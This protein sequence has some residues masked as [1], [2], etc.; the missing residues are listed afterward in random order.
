MLILSFTSFANNSAEK[1]VL[2]SK[3]DLINYQELE[4]SFNQEEASSKSILAYTLSF[5]KPG[6]TKNHPI[7]Y[8]KYAL[9]KSDYLSIEQICELKTLTAEYLLNTFNLKSAQASINEITKE[10]PQEFKVYAQLKQGW[11]YVNK[12]EFQK[13]IDYWINNQVALTE[14]KYWDIA[15]KKMGEILVVNHLKKRKKIILKGKYLSEELLLAGVLEK[16]SKISP[17]E[18]EVKFLKDY[19]QFKNMVARNYDFFESSCDLDYL[20]QN[21]ID[22]EIIIKKINGCLSSKSPQYKKIAPLVEEL[23]DL[24]LPAWQIRAV[25]FS[26]TNQKQMACDA[27]LSCQILSE[28]EDYLKGVRENCNESDLVS[29]INQIGVNSD[30]TIDFMGKNILKL[31]EREPVL[32]RLNEV[33][34]KKLFAYTLND[35]EVSSY[36][37]SK[38]RLSDEDSFQFVLGHSQ[39]IEEKEKFVSTI[40]DQKTRIAAKYILGL[41]LDESLDFAVCDQTP[42][43]QNFLFMAKLTKNIFTP[44]DCFQEKLK[45]DQNL[46][47]HFIDYQLRNEM[48]YQLPSFQKLQPKRDFKSLRKDLYLNSSIKQMNFHKSF[49]KFDDYEFFNTISILKNM[50]NKVLKNQWLSQELRKRTVESFNQKLSRIKHLAARKIQDKKL[51]T[52]LEEMSL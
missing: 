41:P 1:L 24:T 43:L 47:A 22:E 18:L 48:N 30:I 11:L 13:A 40:Q 35:F 42:I 20:S 4:E 26:Q 28:Q 21:S 33:Q 2:F 6:E 10:C 34:L 51:M 45:S 7:Y 49:F 29:V 17:Y 39:S 15:L 14:N 9:K 3:K 52:F 12:G 31:K 46:F 5:A 16:L 36:I 27:Y 25:V 44:E 19:P 8:T 50:R 37:K 38:V 32:T 23:K